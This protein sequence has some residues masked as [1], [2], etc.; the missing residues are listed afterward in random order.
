M[1]R[2]QYINK[3]G[4]MAWLG[5]ESLNREVKHKLNTFNVEL[6]SKQLNALSELIE[7]HIRRVNY[8][9]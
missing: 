1:T 5:R 4:Y 7:E 8:E 3:H 9:C 6:T 2:N